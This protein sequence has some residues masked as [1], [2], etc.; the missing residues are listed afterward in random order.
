VPAT[1]RGEP[2]APR[3]VQLGLAPEAVLILGAYLTRKVSEGPTAFAD[4]AERRVVGHLQRMLAEDDARDP[5]YAANLAAA[6][7]RFNG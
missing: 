2:L 5:R 6:R 7:I 4:E 1:Q 3:L